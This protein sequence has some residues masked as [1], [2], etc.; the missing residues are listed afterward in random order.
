MADSPNSGGTSR[1]KVGKV[2]NRYS[3]GGTGQKLEEYWVG[4]DRESYSLRELAEY[5]NKELLRSALAKTAQQRLD[6]DIDTIY[7]TLRDEDVSRGEQV[8]VRKTLEH[9]GVDVEQ[10]QRDFV[11]HQAIHT[12]LTK[13][14]GVEKG[15]EAGD[16]IESARQTINGLRGRLVAVVETT[17]SNLR[18]TDIFTLGSFDIFVEIN[19][20]CTD[21]GSH[22]NISKLLN[23]GGCECDSKK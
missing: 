2:M 23:D 20:L 21:C 18:K 3:L 5:F 7:R 6:G 17:L 15:S 4:D 16:R 12:Y 22:K 9:D 11:T 14:R 19:V 13:G 1:Y 8:H 10:L